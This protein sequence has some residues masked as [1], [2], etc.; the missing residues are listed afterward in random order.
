M[1]GTTFETFERNARDQL[2]R[3]LGKGGFQ[4]SRDVLAITVN[5]WSHGYA[6]EYSPLDG[7]GWPEGQTPCEIGR[8]RFGRIA[9]ANS[10]AG[11]GGHTEAAIDQAHRAVAELLEASAG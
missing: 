2:Q 10:D 9:I 5:R 11:A 4:A 3:L 6:Y 8:R 7:P 1:Q